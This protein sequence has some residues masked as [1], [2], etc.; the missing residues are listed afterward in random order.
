MQLLATELAKKFPNCVIYQS[1]CYTPKMENSQQKI[2][3]ADIIV[4]TNKAEVGVNYNVEYC[5]MQP[6]KYYQNFI[7]RFGRVAR[8]I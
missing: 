5:I 1:T 4:A 7:Q 6:G 2:K 8:G 3:E